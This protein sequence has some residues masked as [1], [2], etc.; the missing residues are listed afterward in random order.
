MTEKLSGVTPQQAKQGKLMYVIEAAVE[1]FIALIIAGQYLTNLSLHLGIDQAYSSI[2]L[3][4]VQ[5]G[6]V[7]QL[8]GLF[9][10]KKKRVKG[11]VTLLHTVNQAAFALIYLV[12]F[13][14]VPPVVKHVFFIAF[15][16]IGY[17]LSNFI[18]AP[19]LSWYMTFVDANERGRFTATK[20]IWSLI[21]GVVFSYIISFVIEHF[22]GIG[23]IET[24][25]L[26]SAISIFLLAAVHT[27]VLIFTPNVEVPTSSEPL[28]NALKSV[29]TSKKAWKVFVVQIVYSI[30]S[31][32]AIAT[33]L[34]F[35]KYPAEKFG[36]GITSELFFATVAAVGALSRV[37]VSRPMGRFADK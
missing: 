19:K 3:S 1:Y 13:V 20:E 17:F 32:T 27:L 18:G 36:L 6:Y 4:F 14:P 8:F 12:P 24:A 2:L 5:L 31:T 16:I 9:L 23:Q 7:F 10:A 37:L 11:M 29:F 15:L 30:I 26:I 33:M 25:F 35:L 22:Q 34:P 21:G 28:G